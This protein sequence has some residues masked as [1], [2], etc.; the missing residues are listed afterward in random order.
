MKSRRSLIFF[1]FKLAF[2]TSLVSFAIIAVA[3]FNSHLEFYY[4]HKNGLYS[5]VSAFLMFLLF[6]GKSEFLISGIS[7]EKHDLKVMR[8]VVTTIGLLIF[9]LNA[10]YQYESSALYCLFIV[11]LIWISVSIVLIYNYHPKN[12]K[13]KTTFQE[14]QF[15]E[16]P[17][18]D[19]SIIS[20]GDYI[21]EP[22]FVSHGASEWVSD[23][24]KN[25]LTDRLLNEPTYNGL[26]I[27]GG[28]FHHKEGNL[29]SIAPPG[30]GKGAALIIPNLLWSRKYEH[31]FVVFDPKGTNACITARF[32]RDSQGHKVIIIDP[33][34]LQGANNAKHGIPA[35]NFNPL[36]HIKDDIFNGTSQIANLL[37]PDDPNGDKF[38]TQD[39]RNLVQAI[40]MHIMTD[41]QYSERRSLVTFYKIMLT[42]DFEELLDEMIMNSAIDDVIAEFASGYKI[43]MNKSEQTFASV[44]SVANASIKWLSNPALQRC[45]S[46]SDFNPNELEKGG[47]TLYLC[48]PIQ[49]KEGFATFSRLVVGFC[50]RANSQPSAKPKA[51]VYYL[52]DEFPTMGI[53]PEVVESLAYSREYKMRIWLFVQSLSQL[54]QIYKT[55]G[56]HQ[57]LGN[58]RV[59][60]AFGVTDHVTQEYISKRIGNKTIK[61]QTQSSSSGTNSSSGRGSEGSYSTSQGSSHTTSFNEAFH[62]KPLIEPSALQFDPHIITI[63]E[64]GPMRLSRWQYWQK[65]PIAGFYVDV[66]NDG[67]ADKNPNIESNEENDPTISGPEGSGQFTM[68]T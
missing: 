65:D 43:M 45:L 39:A 66:F 25:K 23:R 17:Q 31:S 18:E 3:G 60:Q 49:N 29:V 4:G 19:F 50:L 9:I 1:L 63:S 30:T 52:L 33:M 56:R 57:I 47:V 6:K 46:S 12:D 20:T 53:F 61:V 41:D 26:W 10:I 22:E 51:W 54:D 40:L 16:Q 32:Q 48:Q 28:F 35:A 58:A 21:E 34:N 37:M 62:G 11:P 38:F 36:D 24:K 14:K 15:Q 64:W 7:N 59:L 55:E 13:K 5:L 42:A 8:I 27:G 68:T 2:V 67:R 44:R